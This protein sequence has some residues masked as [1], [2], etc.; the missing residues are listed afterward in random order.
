MPTLKI[1]LYLRLPDDRVYSNIDA[2]PKMLTEAIENYHTLP[3][4]THVENI[5]VNPVEIVGRNR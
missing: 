1:E 5:I 4:N 3:E 2:I